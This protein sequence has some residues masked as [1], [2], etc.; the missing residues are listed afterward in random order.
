MNC[1]ERLCLRHDFV[2]FQHLLELRLFH[3]SLI[4]IIK[5]FHIC[6]SLVWSPQLHSVDGDI[7]LLE[8]LPPLGTDLQISEVRR[9]STSRVVVTIQDHSLSHCNILPRYHDLL[10]SRSGS[11]PALEILWVDVQELDAG[12]ERER[13]LGIVE[14]RHRVM[15]SETSH[16]RI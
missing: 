16:Y 7:V 5:Q 1:T 12:E 3:P 6:L 9:T 4:L 11:S 15:Y 10:H 8:N 13:E 14:S 2:L